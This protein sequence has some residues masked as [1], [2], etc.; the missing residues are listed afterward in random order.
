LI[1]VAV[2]IPTPDAHASNRGTRCGKCSAMIAAYSVA[3]DV[4]PLGKLNLLDAITSAIKS[5]SDSV[6]LR[7]RR[8]FL[9]MR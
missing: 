2:G 9:A 7:W 1:R 6:G 4:W 8:L 5:G 3:A